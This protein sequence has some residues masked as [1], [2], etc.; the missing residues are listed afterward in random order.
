MTGSLHLP[1]LLL[2]FG[3]GRGCPGQ[4]QGPAQLVSHAGN[5]AAP[6]M[7]N[8]G[9]RTE[10]WQGGAAAAHAA[11]A[12]MTACGACFT[13]WAAWHAVPAAASSPCMCRKWSRRCPQGS[14]TDRGTSG[15][16]WPRPSGRQSS[17]C[18]CSAREAVRGAVRVGGAA[19]APR[20]ADGRGMVGGR[21][22]APTIQLGG[23][24][25][26]LCGTAAIPLP[27]LLVALACTLAAAAAATVAAE[28]PAE[29]GAAGKWGPSALT[30]SQVG[31]H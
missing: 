22:A 3:C 19:A 2:H 21:D 23:H 16:G 26:P 24:A 25:S 17:A 6:D 27:S 5:G 18:R 1:F 29:A 13:I 11:A 31:A 7:Q 30:G 15:R 20:R 9:A 12:T 10:Q 4:S 14:R 28:V 8:A